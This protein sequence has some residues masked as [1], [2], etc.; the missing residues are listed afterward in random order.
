MFMIDMHGTFERAVASSSSRT[1]GAPYCG[2]CIARPT[3]SK[4]DG[5]T[6]DVVAAE[7]LPGRLREEIS[8]CDPPFTGRRICVPSA[9]IMSASLGRQTRVTLCPAIASLVARSDP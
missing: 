8:T 7:I 6:W 5:S 1:P 4:F 2:S 9:L 3:R